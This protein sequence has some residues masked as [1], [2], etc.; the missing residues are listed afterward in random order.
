MTNKKQQKE[1]EEKERE[2]IIQEIKE[3]E[4]DLVAYN[5]SFEDYYNIPDRAEVGEDYKEM[6]ASL[7]DI[8]KTIEN[9]SQKYTTEQKQK[10]KD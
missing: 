1:E 2:K 9:L 3:L 8:S 5:E 6:V 7:E 4:N 10:S